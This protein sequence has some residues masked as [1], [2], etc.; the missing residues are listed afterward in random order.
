[1]ENNKYPSC[2]LSNKEHYVKYVADEDNSF[3]TA[4]LREARKRDKLHRKSKALEEAMSVGL[5]C[6]EVNGSIHITMPDGKT[7]IYYPQARKWRVKGKGRY[8][9]TFGI[10]QAVGTYKKNM[11]C[12]FK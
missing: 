9:K 3:P 5:P 10:K 8:Y 6:I 2:K 7:L 1:M 4:I 12:S 11:D